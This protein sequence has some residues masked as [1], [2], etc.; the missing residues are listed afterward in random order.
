VGDKKLAEELIEKGLKM[1]PM[2]G[3]FV[4]YKTRYID[5]ITDK[6][7]LKAKFEEIKTMTS[8]GMVHL[9]IEEYDYGC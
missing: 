8:N 4:Y 5:K 1:A 2:D 7:E 6:E 9:E 3:E